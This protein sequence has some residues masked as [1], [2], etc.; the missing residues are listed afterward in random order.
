MK[1][2]VVRGPVLTRTGYGEHTRFLLRSLRTIEDK[3]DIYLLPIAWGESNWIWEDNEEREWYDLLIKKTAMYAQHGEGK[4]DVSIQVTIPNEW[5]GLAPVNIGVTA[6]IETTKVAPLWLQNANYMD[7]LIVV[8][9]HAKTSFETTMYT[10]T[11]K[12]KEE[13]TLQCEKDISVVP[14]P[15]KSYN[16]VEL[17]LNLSTD[18]NF[19]TIAQWGPRK[20]IENT[21]VWFV[22]EFIDNPKVG[23]V[24]KAFGRGGSLID[25]QAVTNK[26]KQVLSK[27]ENRKCKVYLLHGDLSEDEMHSL[28][29]HQQI[30]AFVSLTH[31][32]GYGL[33][34]FEA[35]YCGLPVIAP[36]W[37]GYLDFLR[38]PVKNKKGKVKNKSHF[39]C[40]DF[41]IRPV[42]KEAVWDGV[43]QADSMWCFAQQGSY[44]M[45]L[46]EVSKDY[47]RFKKQAKQLQTWILKNFAEDK[48]LN[49][50]VEELKDFIIDEGQDEWL[51]SLD[52]IE[53]I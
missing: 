30:K 51:K 46:R 52:Q 7:K 38:M 23:L 15:V 41:D 33:P 39:A 18:F 4:Y 45:K 8:S 35:A 22:E 49:Q 13:V 43:L 19:L 17:D 20:N 34:H 1:K 28:Y 2:V 25:R 9:N 48:I 10:G 14:Y 50:L 11:N 40:V 21:I 31:G 16:K 26:L 37:S 36:E 44:K 27:Y 3:I 42:Q 12:E 53:M 47:G 29:S 6:G 32:E 5:K 24:V